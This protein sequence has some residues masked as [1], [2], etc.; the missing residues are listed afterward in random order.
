MT[1]REYIA[2][3]TDEYEKIRYV[4]ELAREYPE[5]EKLPTWKRQDILKKILDA[6]VVL[7]T[8]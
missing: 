7:Q 8:E 1:N 5:Y 4:A 2:S 6:E 3:I